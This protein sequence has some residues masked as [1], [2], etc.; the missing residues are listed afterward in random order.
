MFDNADGILY[1]SENIN[2][3]PDWKLCD[4]LLGKAANA[5]YEATGIALA[6]ADRLKRAKSEVENATKIL[7]S[8]GLD[9]IWGDATQMIIKRADTELEEK[10]R[11][12]MENG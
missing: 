1:S 5:I 2:Q 12:L 4:K 8:C 3:S 6:S 9:P 11:I 7:V 10:Y